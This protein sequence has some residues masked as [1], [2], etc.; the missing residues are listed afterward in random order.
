VNKQRIKEQ[1]LLILFFVG[2]FVF[3]FPA[4]SVLNRN[5]MFA[6]IPVLYLYIF[7]AWL[8]LVGLMAWVVERYR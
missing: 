5:A 8:V 7:I 2:M 3:N 4:L 1:R 6:N